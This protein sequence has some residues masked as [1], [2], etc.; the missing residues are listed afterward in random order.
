MTARETVR[1]GTKGLTNE[2]TR[3]TSSRVAKKK[4]KDQRSTPGFCERPAFGT[5]PPRH[6]PQC[7]PAF[8]FVTMLLRQDSL[9]AS[10]AS[11]GERGESDTRG[12]YERNY[13]AEEAFISRPRPTLYS[14]RDIRRAAGPTT[15]AVASASDWTTTESRATTRSPTPTTARA[16]PTL[17]AQEGSTERARATPAGP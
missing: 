17:S 13:Y 1:G 2:Y 6:A 8:L 14:T 16:P 11:R 12:M 4:I 15:A 5:R 10:M 7:L 3:L 9:V